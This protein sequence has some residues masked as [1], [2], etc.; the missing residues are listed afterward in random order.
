MGGGHKMDMFGFLGFIFG[1]M[2]FVLAT[3]S[4]G[5]ISELKKE[6]QKLKDQG[7]PK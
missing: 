5:Q 4:M 6:V 7:P 3:T 1:I 2:G